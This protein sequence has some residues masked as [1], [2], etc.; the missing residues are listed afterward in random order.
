[1]SILE[2]VEAFDFPPMLP[3]LDGVGEGALKGG[4][5][6]RLLPTAAGEG[7]RRP[8]LAPASALV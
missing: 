3:T 1:M 4:D 2:F 7:E 6:E 5:T 8:L